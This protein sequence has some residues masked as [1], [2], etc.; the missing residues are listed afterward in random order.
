VLLEAMA[1]GTP[2]VASR[3]GGIPEIVDPDCG[4]LVEPD[5]VAAL[6]DAVADVLGAG[7]HA[8]RDACTR[9]AGRNDLDTN[10]RRFADLLD[11]VA[12]QQTGESAHG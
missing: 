1:C 10:A 4:R 2:C 9:A 8:F 6:A 5:D 11:R 7:K 3:V 12:R